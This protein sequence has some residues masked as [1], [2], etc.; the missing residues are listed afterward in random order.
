MRLGGGCGGTKEVTSLL[1]LTCFGTAGKDTSQRGSHIAQSKVKDGIEAEHKSEK[2]ST[3]KLKPVND[4]FECIPDR[5]WC[6]QD[7]QVQH[8]FLSVLFPVAHSTEYLG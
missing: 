7:Q 8:S 4:M 1:R 5:K 2:S 6:V 3:Y